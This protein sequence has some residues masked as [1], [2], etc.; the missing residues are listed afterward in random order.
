M[1]CFSKLVHQAHCQ[2]KLLNI[3]KIKKNFKWSPKVSLEEGLKKT[4]KFYENKNLIIKKKDLKF[5]IK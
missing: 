4:I 3:Q 5:S 2:K 1:E